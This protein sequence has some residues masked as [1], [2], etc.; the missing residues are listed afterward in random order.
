MKRKGTLPDRFLPSFL[1]PVPNGSI[2]FDS[3]ENYQLDTHV[4][5]I[6]YVW[7]TGSVTVTFVFTLTHSFF[8]RANADRES[9]AEVTCKVARKNNRT[10]A[11]IGTAVLCCVAVAN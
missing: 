11:R 5:I 4:K 10:D 7:R 3:S 2:S 9:F 1:G 6:R 8:K